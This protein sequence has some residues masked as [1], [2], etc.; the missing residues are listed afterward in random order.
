MYR[1]VFCN[2]DEMLRQYEA[3]LFYFSGKYAS[4]LCTLCHEIFT[5][6]M[7]R[8]FDWSYCSLHEW[9]FLLSL[10]IGAMLMIVQTDLIQTDASFNRI[11]YWHAS[12]D[13]R[14]WVWFM[15]GELSVLLVVSRSR[16]ELLGTEYSF[17]TWAGEVTY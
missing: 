9:N 13:V 14:K 17:E 8:W 1:C 5:K 7:K 10:I 3:K 15:N 4:L 12:H 11:L 16:V 6:I 2:L